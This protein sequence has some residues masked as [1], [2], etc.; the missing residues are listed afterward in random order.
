MQPNTSHEKQV[1][2]NL[3]TSLRFPEYEDRCVTVQ[4]YLVFSFLNNKYVLL[5]INNLKTTLP[6]A[7]KE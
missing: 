4:V 7:L 2:L 6:I 1:N 5:W 3:K